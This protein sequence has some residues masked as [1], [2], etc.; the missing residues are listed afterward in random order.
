MTEQGTVAVKRRLVQ[1]LKGG[2]IM[3]ITTADETVRRWNH[4]DA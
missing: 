3:D 4:V 2:V 1:M